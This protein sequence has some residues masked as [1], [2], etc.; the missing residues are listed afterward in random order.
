MWLTGL[1]APRHVESSQT[2]ARTRVPCIGRQTL[3][4]CATR[5]APPQAFWRLD[6][7]EQRGLQAPSRTVTCPSLSL[8]CLDSGSPHGPIW[9]RSSP[10]SCGKS[11]TWIQKQAQLPRCCDPT[12]MQTPECAWAETSRRL[13]QSDLQG[14][15]RQEHVISAGDFYLNPFCNPS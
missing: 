15:L 5:E 2:R 6:S 1:I 8:D 7:P 12:D 4:D 11:C 14:S 13:P 10:S 3:N 9:P